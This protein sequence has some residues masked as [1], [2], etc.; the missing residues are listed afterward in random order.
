[1]R[2]LSAFLAAGLLAM[3]VTAA[4]AKILTYKL[5]GDFTATFNIDTEAPTH[6]G[7]DDSGVYLYGV[8]GTFGGYQ[9]NTVMIGFPTAE[10]G[11]GIEASTYGGG[12]STQSV[13][14]R[15]Y[16]FS[17]AGPL[18]FT[19]TLEA[20]TFVTG[21]W[22]LTEYYETGKTYRLDVSAAAVPEPMTWAL[23]LG[24]F[25]LAGAALRRRTAQLSVT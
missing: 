20:P 22:N 12:P 10:L 4:E 1:M 6:V 8:N 2:V 17:G 14:G 21:S 7:L 16:F 5:T 24:G 23:M 9:F 11:G 19:G 15:D 3:S 25:G 13:F 18:L